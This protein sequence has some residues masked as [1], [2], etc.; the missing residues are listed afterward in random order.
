M[1]VQVTF[2]NLFSTVIDTSALRLGVTSQL[3]TCFTENDDGQLR[4]DTFVTLMDYDE[5]SISGLVSVGGVG[6]QFSSLVPLSEISRFQSLEVYPGISMVVQEPEPEPQSWKP[7][8][9]YQPGSIVEY[10]DRLWEAMP[11]VAVG[12][13]PDPVFDVGSNTGGWKPY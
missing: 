7:D 8:E 6:S 2:P 10:E 3:S 12:Y 1:K 4:V 9:R 11:D 5:L 13:R